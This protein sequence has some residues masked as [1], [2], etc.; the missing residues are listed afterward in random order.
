MKSDTPSPNG[1]NNR[2]DIPPSDVEEEVG[3]SYDPGETLGRGMG[4]ACSLVLLFFALV[5]CGFIISVLS[6][7]R[8][9]S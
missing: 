9:G 3:D 4:I 2:A 6:S 1:G 5:S 8:F 7:H